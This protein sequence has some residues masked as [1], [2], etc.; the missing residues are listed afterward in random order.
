MLK[1]LWS[2]DGAYGQ[3][4]VIRE[5]RRTGELDRVAAGWLQDSNNG[6]VAGR[7]ILLVLEHNGRV[8]RVSV[9]A[10][11][12][13]CDWTFLT[14]G[15]SLFDR[16]CKRFTFVAALSIICT[17]RAF[18]IYITIISARL[19]VGSIYAESAASSAPRSIFIPAVVVYYIFADV[20]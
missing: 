14:F 6:S 5:Y 8:L 10:E 3:C 13:K 20:T 2:A 17:P 12:R 11:K 19:S 7:K 15:D 4:A 1:D 16:R 18:L 9:V